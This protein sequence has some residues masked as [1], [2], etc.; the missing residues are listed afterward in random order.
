MT[1]IPRLPSEWERL[2]ALD[3]S[4]LN[5]QL[6]ALLAAAEQS[7][8][9]IDFDRLIGAGRRFAG[10]GRV[11]TDAIAVS[12]L[13]ARPSAR[14][15]DVVS[16]FLTGLWSTTGAELSVQHDVLAAFLEVRRACTLGDEVAY[17]SLLPVSDVAKRSS[18]APVQSLARAALEAAR[19]EPYRGPAMAEQARKL[20]DAALDRHS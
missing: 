14:R 20:I 19:A 2:F 8:P 1:G 10:A 18:A 17:S 7:A 16:G 15:L 12:W 3:E 9:P 11:H 13:T 5:E 4:D 6:V